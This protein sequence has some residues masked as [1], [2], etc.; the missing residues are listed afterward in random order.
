MMIESLSFA[1]P[2][3]LMLVEDSSGGEEPTTMD[4]SA[5]VST[6][7]CIAVGCQCDA[8]GETEFQ[9]GARAEV[10]PGTQPIFQ[11][12][13]Q[14]PSRKVV[15][16]SVLGDII[17]QAPVPGT[18]TMISIWTNHPTAPDQVIVGVE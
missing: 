8:D 5:I 9:L 1:A 7:S 15:I 2:Y 11:G 12:R 16:R 18:E 13:I 10:D 14:T 4:E 3:C 17:L 6:E